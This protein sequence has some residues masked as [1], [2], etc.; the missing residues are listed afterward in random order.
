MRSGIMSLFVL[1]AAG[2]VVVDAGA[3][4]N[5]AR[6]GD[7]EYIEE[8]L[9]AGADVNEK[10]ANELTP[11]HWAAIQGHHHVVDVLLEAGADITAEDE[12]GQHPLHFAKRYLHSQMQ[13]KLIEKGADVEHAEKV[14]HGTPE[15][16]RLLSKKRRAKER[17]AADA[18]EANKRKFES[19]RAACQAA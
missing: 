7:L 10:S 9:E 1:Y 16:A 18:D 8:L 6:D 14:L 15:S 19:D 13:D 12:I 3:L 11:L 17:Q 2:R 5:A 4:H